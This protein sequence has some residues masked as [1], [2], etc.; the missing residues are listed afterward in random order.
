MNKTTLLFFITLLLFSWSCNLID[1]GRN[2]L[3]R[4]QITVTG[5]DTFKTITYY[6]PDGK[7]ETVLAYKNSVLHGVSEV[8][9]PEGEIKQ[10]KT[11][12]NDKDFGSFVQYYRNGNVSR[13][14]F[15]ID[16]LRNSYERTYDDQGNLIQIAGDPLAAFRVLR[17][18]T[19]DTIL[20]KAYFSDFDAKDFEVFISETGEKESFKPFSLVTDSGSISTKEGQ[21]KLVKKINFPYHY[22]IQM[23]IRN[24][25]DSIENYKDEISFYVSR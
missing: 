19:S 21:I 1:K 18:D 7:K 4:E 5:L 6:L 23:K 24:G 15:L 13:Y 16:S 14:S 20:V 10:K 11:F 22:Y 25:K 12:V 17:S 9:Y 8:Y 3:R 2:D